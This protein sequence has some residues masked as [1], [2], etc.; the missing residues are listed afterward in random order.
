MKRFST[1]AGLTLLLASSTMAGTLPKCQN[2]PSD[3]QGWNGVLCY[4]MVGGVTTIA[5]PIELSG[6]THASS[7]QS[8]NREEYVGYVREDAAEFVAA[9]G[10]AP[11]DALLADVI[12]Q[13]RLEVP[14][15]EQISDLE[16]AK[17][18][19]VDFN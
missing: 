19:E 12:K 17:L 4:L 11:V 13:V 1:L 3:W 14:G 7:S 8:Q 15:T 10:N 2:N 5:I 6:T 18:V 16:V 9:D